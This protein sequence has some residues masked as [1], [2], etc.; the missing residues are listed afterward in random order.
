MLQSRSRECRY[1]PSRSSSTGALVI[2]REG[3]DVNSTHLLRAS[4]IAGAIALVAAG[5]CGNSKNNDNA[6]ATSTTSSVLEN[7][8]ST[9]KPLPGAAPIITESANNSTQT[10]AY[11]PSSS[12]QGSLRIS[13]QTAGGSGYTWKITK[14]PD[15][16]LN[17]PFAKPR[18][19]AVP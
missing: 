10:L 4:A 12:E 1:C 18:S 13:L 6:V 11:N 5:A 16:I 7:T 19:V 17:T 3:T 8:T 2:L 15:P 9:A 14:Q